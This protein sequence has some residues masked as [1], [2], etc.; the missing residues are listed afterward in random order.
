MS[1]SDDDKKYSSSSD[2]VSLSD[3]DEYWEK[4]ECLKLRLKLLNEK[5]NE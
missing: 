5:N 4:I 3:D 2:N 1:K